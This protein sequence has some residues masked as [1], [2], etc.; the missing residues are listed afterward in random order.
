ML[1]G[2]N[3]EPPEVR[4]VRPTNGKPMNYWQRNQPY[5]EIFDDPRLAGLSTRIRNV[6]ANNGIQYEDLPSVSYSQLLHLDHMG[7]KSIKELFAWMAD[8]KIQEQL[9]LC[10]H[11][12][13]PL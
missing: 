8:R 6:L 1:A 9:K 11:C 2:M 13:M 3:D 10:R 7:K 12:G 4:L 5:A